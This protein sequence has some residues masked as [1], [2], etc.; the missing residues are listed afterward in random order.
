[1]TIDPKIFK[2]YDIRGIYPEQINEEIAQLIGEAFCYFVKTKY[3]LDYPKI[4][5]NYD[6]RPSSKPL[7][8][9]LKQGLL[10]QGAFVFDGGFST[11]P[12]HYFGNWNLKVDGSIMI[13]ASHNPKEYNGF[14]LFLREVEPISISEG[15]RVI[16]EIFESK[17]FQ[18]ERKE[19]RVEEVSLFEDYLHF[20]E[21]NTELKDFSQIRIAVDFANGCVGPFFEKLAE[22]FNL[23][24]FGLFQEPDGS[25]PNHE[26]NPIKEENLKFLI[27]VIKTKKFDL[28]VAFD[29]D[30]DRLVILDENGK[31]VRADFVLALFVKYYLR[32]IKNLTHESFSV[33]CDARASRGVRDILQEEGVALIKSRVGYPFIKA[34]MRENNSLLGGELSGHFFWKESC[35]SESSFLTL[36]R[37][38]EVLY[39]EKKPISQLVEPM[40]KYFSSKEINFEV[41]NKEEIIKKIEEKYSDG[42]ISKIDGLTVEYKDWWFNIRPSNTEP[43]LRLTVEAKTKELLDKKIRELTE[44]ILRPSNS[45]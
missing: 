19:G 4:L 23:N 28:G 43:V 25:F 12:I 22:E 24:Y 11:T 37:L 31:I 26:A 38:L 41:D 17:E 33:V 7:F 15:T 1:M 6:V 14:K 29:G 27:D 16:K 21:E 34:L 13:T 30:G 35:Y 42:E 18:G 20:L 10:N 5:I 32:K 8:S 9:A 2:A 40:Q 36:L 39:F 44:I 45:F 3:H